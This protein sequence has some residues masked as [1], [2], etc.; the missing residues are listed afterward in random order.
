[1]HLIFITGSSSG[2]G[3]GLAE[4]LLQEDSTCR[5][6]GFARR[7]TW[8]HER[9][10]HIE[11]D[12]ADM[13]QLKAISFEIPTHCTRVS[14]VNNAGVIGDIKR[15]G[16]ADDDAIMHLSQLNVGALMVLTNRFLKAVKNA[17]I[18]CTVLNISSGAARYEI[19]SWAPYCASKA[20]VDHFS[21]TVQ[22]EQTLTSGNARIFSVA[23]GIVDTE[24]QTV[25]RNSDPNDFSRHADFVA[26]KHNNELAS[27]EETA[28]K[29][30]HIL[31]NP[32]TLEDVLIDVRDIS[33]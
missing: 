32:N 9:Y 10:D 31:T 24:M 15:I 19:D 11:A 21:K 25:I 28:Q 1:M 17:D 6:V 29:L 23:P 13:K 12:L 27:V 20:A 18:P 16:A 33:L 2:I 3:K 5:V 7:S 26:L 30:H 4:Y 22:Y 14:L 8:K